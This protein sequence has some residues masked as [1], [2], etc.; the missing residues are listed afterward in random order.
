MCRSDRGAC[1]AQFHCGL[2]ATVLISKSAGRYRVQSS[3][4]EGLWLL[5]DELE[6]RLR[7]YYT[8]KR[9]E[10]EEPFRM[11]YVDPLPLQVSPHCR[12]GPAARVC[13]GGG[14][15]VRRSIST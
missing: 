5:C 6:R 4:F 7:G 8:S 2:D 14:R 15:G 9:D 1:A 3:A 10:A 13:R 12:L 11:S